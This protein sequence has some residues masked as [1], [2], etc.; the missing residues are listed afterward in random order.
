M[1][2]DLL[3]SLGPPPFRFTPTQAGVSRPAFTP[4]FKTLATVIVA[5]GVAWLASL[6]HAGALGTSGRSSGVVW[7]TSGLVL[8]LYTWWHILR[9]RTRIDATALHQTWIW[10]KKLDLRELAYCRLIRVR[11][12]EWLIAPRL[13]ARTLMGKFAVFYAADPVLLADFERLVRE[14]A[15]FRRM[16]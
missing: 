15:D 12:L 5:I 13:Y 9:S 1:N 11:G 4:A 6:W 16:S 3:Q 2:E 14:V 7:L 8:M 10:D